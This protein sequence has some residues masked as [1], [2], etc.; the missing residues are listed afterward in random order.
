MKYNID[1]RVSEKSWHIPARHACRTPQQRAT[2]ASSD[3]LPLVWSPRRY[4]DGESQSSRGLTTRECNTAVSTNDTARSGHA[5]QGQRR[6]RPVHQARDVGLR[7]PVL[8]A[9]FRGAQLDAPEAQCR[10]SCIHGAV[11]HIRNAISG[12]SPATFPIDSFQLT[13]CSHYA[14]QAWLLKAS[15]HIEEDC[16]ERKHFDKFPARLRLAIRPCKQS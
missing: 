2:Q 8:I 16:P 1:T 5:G 3:I 15:R 13:L 6:S 11:Y 12:S 4:S 7:R 10:P 9:G 14:G